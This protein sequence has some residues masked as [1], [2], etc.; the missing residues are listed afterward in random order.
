MSVFYDNSNW[1]VARNTDDL[2]I[3]NLDYLKHLECLPAPLVRWT[4]K[5]V[6]FKFICDKGG[7]LM[8][9]PIVLCLSLVLLIL[10]PFLNSGPLFFRQER[11]GMGG[12]PFPMW[13]FRTMTV[14]PE[15]ARPHDAPLEEDR[16]TPLGRFLRKYRIDELPNFFNVLVG[17]MSLVGPR[18]D[19]W[20][21]SRHYASDVS[22]YSERFRVR[23]GITGLAQ[24]NIGYADTQNVVRR[25]ARLDSFYVRH[26][27][28]RLDLL[29][30]KRT[31]FVVLTGFGGK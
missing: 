30:L 5:F 2:R 1:V 8:A 31:L 21:H 18:P 7:A 26:S 13:K 9:L 14:S 11:M 16:I 17:D 15:S 28:I 27:R 24:V 23:P 19:A 3:S 29:I 20:D 25:K 12:R 22:Y 4:P 10:N 6:A